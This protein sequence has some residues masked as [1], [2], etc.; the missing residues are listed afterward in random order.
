MCSSD[1]CFATDDIDAELARLQTAGVALLDRAARPSISGRIAFLDPRG[2]HGMLVQLVEPDPAFPTSDAPGIDHLATLVADY[3]AARA[4]WQRALGFEVA[5]EIPV[6]QLAN[7]LPGGVTPIVPG[8]TRLTNP[9][10]EGQKAGCHLLVRHD[11]VFALRMDR[12]V[13]G[14]RAFQQIEKPVASADAARAA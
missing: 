14:R 6:P 10:L 8:G 2:M 1:L 13:V 11:V 5:R 9:A 3:P 7:M 4:A 12:G